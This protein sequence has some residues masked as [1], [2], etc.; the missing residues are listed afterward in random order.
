[1]L[2]LG[3]VKVE[4]AGRPEREAGEDGGLEIEFEGAEEEEGEEGDWEEGDGEGG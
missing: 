2:G 1:M 4:E 3:E